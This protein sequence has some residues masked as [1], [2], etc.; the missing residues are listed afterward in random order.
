MSFPR[1][2]IDEIER[3]FGLH[4][5]TEKTGP[6]HD[7]VRRAAKQYA[8]A[9]IQLVPPGREQGL[10]LTAAQESAMWANAAIA[11]D[12]ANI[13]ASGVKAVDPHSVKTA[14]SFPGIGRRR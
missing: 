14:N 4:P 8:T 5:A 6:M 11:C 1:V 9:L 2:D 12:P 10:A 3:R 13:I 7:A